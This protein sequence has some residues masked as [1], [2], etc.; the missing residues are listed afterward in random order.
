[1]KYGELH[2]EVAG[3]DPDSGTDPVHRLAQRRDENQGDHG[4]QHVEDE[5]GK[6]Q[7][8]ALEV[9]ADRADDRRDRGSDIG[10]DCQRERILIADLACREGRQDQNHRRVARLHDNGRDGAD[11]RVDKEADQTG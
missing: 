2:R 6:R 4:G 3:C 7:A 5:M 9:R 10:A 8:L 1:M 11:E